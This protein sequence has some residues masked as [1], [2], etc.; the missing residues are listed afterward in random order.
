M[1]CLFF[2]S[3]DGG[4]SE[5]GDCS[6]TCGGGTQTRTCTNPSPSNTG[7]DCTS[8]GASEQDCNPDACPGIYIFFKVSR[9][10]S[11]TFL[12]VLKK[13]EEGEKV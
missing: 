13:K 6:A 11:K 2:S 8:L 7:A 5:W 10:R 4:Y 9:L 3:V 1:L 12:F